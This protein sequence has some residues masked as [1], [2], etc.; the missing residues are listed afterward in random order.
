VMQAEAADAAETRCTG[1]VSAENELAETRISCT[2]SGSGVRLAMPSREL[3][4][5]L[6]PS[7]WYSFCSWRCLAALIWMPGCFWW[8]KS[9]MSNTSL[10]LTEADVR[11]H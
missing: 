5:T 8:R 9:R 10:G 1:Q 2:V 11:F 3:P 7:T 4:F 6:V